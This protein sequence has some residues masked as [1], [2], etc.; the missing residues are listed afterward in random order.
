MQQ[1]SQPQQVASLHPQTDNSV[2]HRPL[3]NIKHQLM[4]PQR[5]TSNMVASPQNQEEEQ[6]AT[7]GQEE[8]YEPFDQRRRMSVGI[9]PSPASND[10]MVNY[11]NGPGSFGVEGRT[12]QTSDQVASLPSQLFEDRAATVGQLGPFFDSNVG[13]Y[14][15]NASTDCGVNQNGG[16]NIILGTVANN[17]IDPALRQMR[18]QPYPT[19][20]PTQ[21]YDMLHVDE[22]AKAPFMVHRNGQHDVIH[23]QPNATGSFF[24]P[25][26]QFHQ[27]QS[28][29]TGLDAVPYLANQIYEALPQVMGPAQPDT[30]PHTEGHFH[31]AQSQ[32]MGPYVELR[33]LHPTDSR[34]DL[35]SAQS[36]VSMKMTAASP[37]QQQHVQQSSEKTVAR[38]KKPLTIL[39][40]PYRP[41]N[42]QDFAGCGKSG[43]KKEDG[44]WDINTEQNHYE[45]FLKYHGRQ[46]LPAPVGKTPF[47]QR[48]ETIKA[49]SASDRK[50]LMDFVKAE[51]FWRE[52]KEL[53]NPPNVAYTSSE[54]E[55]YES[56]YEDESIDEE[57]H[58]SDSVD[59]SGKQRMTASKKRFR[60]DEKMESTEVPVA[61]HNTRPIKKIR[62]N[63]LPTETPQIPQKEKTQQPMRNRKAKLAFG[64][65]KAVDEH[66]A[67]EG[68]PSLLELANEHLASKGRRT[69]RLTC[70][71]VTA[72][73]GLGSTTSSGAD[74][75]NPSAIDAST[76]RL[77]SSCN[78]G[79]QSSNLRKRKARTGS[80]ESGNTKTIGSASN[81]N[82]TG[83]AEMADVQ[84][85]SALPKRQKVQSKTQR[86]SQKKQAVTETHPENKDRQFSTVGPST[87]NNFTPV[88]TNHGEQSDSVAM[89]HSQHGGLDIIGQDYMPSTS[90]ES[91]R[92]NH[93]GAF[94]PTHGER[95]NSYGSVIISPYINWE[96]AEYHP[97]AQKTSGTVFPRAIMEHTNFSV[98]GSLSQING[99]AASEEGWDT[100]VADEALLH[101]GF[102][103][104]DGF[105]F[106]RFLQDYPSAPSDEEANHRF[107]FEDKLLNA[108]F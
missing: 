51:R 21:Q 65:L 44:N 11:K 101:N 105:D 84:E 37:Q 35:Q 63:Q 55:G 97:M 82:Q 42:C 38:T 96:G 22:V 2:S 34:L 39:S 66:M 32:G 102:E 53:P 28:Q 14:N 25:A 93:V 75:S 78:S 54:E 16:G 46:A 99:Q 23:P 88:P 9:T 19:R 6:L 27:A 70:S 18:Q 62:T 108:Q 83:S 92:L 56:R 47:T 91:T 26:G 12:L 107:D 98:P 100:Q 94:Q 57:E 60:D 104:L 61:T 17:A 3:G 10:L 90:V 15:G 72:L 48:T 33:N 7:S 1:D 73:P 8:P 67:R 64:S 76:H 69:I 106:E 24:D 87:I 86:T 77:E 59:K 13:F 58:E 50:L 45:A 79:T 103:D 68:H 81:K 74:L 5:H 43:R 31:P 41:Y 95:S 29:Q 36:Y 40:R 71:L 80:E 49:L 4:Q 30:L 85:Q 52:Y 20:Q 89:Y